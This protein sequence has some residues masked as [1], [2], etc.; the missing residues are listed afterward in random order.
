M[1]PVDNDP[2]G[3]LVV[4]KSHDVLVAVHGAHKL[5]EYTTHGK[6]VREVNIP[7]LTL[8]HAIQLS[9]GHFGV[10]HQGADNG[11]RIVDANGQIIASYCKSQ[12][13]GLDQMKS[14]R[15]IAINKRGFV[16]IA[17]IRKTIGLLC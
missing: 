14:P 13:S 17:G 4:H 3:L 6:L 11:Y 2:E 9:N 16:F 7:S 15:G 5:Q 12:G 1:W 8:V 10:T